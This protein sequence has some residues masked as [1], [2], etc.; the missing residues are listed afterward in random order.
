MSLDLADGDFVAGG[1][2]ESMV[3]DT[4]SFDLTMAPAVF[5]GDRVKLFGLVGIGFLTSSIGVTE[6]NVGDR[7]APV[8]DRE[9]WHFSVPVGLGAAF[10]LIPDWLELGA[11]VWVSPTF[12]EGGDGLV[13]G[14][15][16][17]GSGGVRRVAPMPSIPLWV[18]QTLTL[19]IVL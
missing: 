19:G 13:D 18:T 17:D 3:Q 2:I 8:A 10:H 4:F 16:Y 1:V 11:R 9:R 6:V 7:R 5:L 12:G 15:V 14:S